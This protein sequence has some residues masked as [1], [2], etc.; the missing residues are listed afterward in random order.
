VKPPSPEDELVLPCEKDGVE[1]L[2]SANRCLSR[3]ENDGVEGSCAKQGVTMKQPTITAKPKATY[4]ISITS[5][6]SFVA[7][8]A[9]LR[10]EGFADGINEVSNRTR[11]ENRDR[12][13]SAVIMT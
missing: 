4:L 9:S 3:S 11:N 10:L 5:F 12:H 13:V 7:F 8:H 1:P 6:V 2:S